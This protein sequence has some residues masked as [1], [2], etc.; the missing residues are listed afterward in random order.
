MQAGG[1]GAYE[2]RAISGEGKRRA[3]REGSSS[4]EA[5]LKKKP[6]RTTHQEPL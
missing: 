1:R 6:S 5:Y 4:S 3:R 2:K